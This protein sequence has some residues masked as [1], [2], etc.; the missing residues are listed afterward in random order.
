MIKYYRIYVRK[1]IKAI[2]A[3]GLVRAL[4]LLWTLP[5]EKKETL[6]TKEEAETADMSVT[7]SAV[8]F[9]DQHRK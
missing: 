5:C 3:E 4:T 6:S 1:G 9:S 2:F 8:V 7:L